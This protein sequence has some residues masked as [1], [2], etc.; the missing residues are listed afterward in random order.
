MR[1]IGVLPHCLPA[2]KKGRCDWVAE[3]GS[4]EIPDTARCAQALRQFGLSGNSQRTTAVVAAR[5][6]VVVAC[7]ER[8]TSDPISMILGVT[9]VDAFET[10][11][12][13]KPALNSSAFVEALGPGVRFGYFDFDAGLVNMADDV[14]RALGSFYDAAGDGAEV[15]EDVIDVHLVDVEIARELAGTSESDSSSSHLHYDSFGDVD[16]DVAFVGGRMVLSYSGGLAVVA[17]GGQVRDRGSFNRQYSQ[18]NTG[19]VGGAFAPVFFSTGSTQHGN[20]VRMLSVAWPMLAGIR[21]SGGIV[22]PEMPDSMKDEIESGYSGLIDLDADSLLVQDMSLWFIEANLDVLFPDNQGITDALKTS[23]L[24][25][26]GLGNHLTMPTVYHEKSSY[27]GSDAVRVALALLRTWISDYFDKEDCCVGCC[28][29]RTQVTV[30]DLSAVFN[31]G[32]GEVRVRAK[33]VEASDASGDKRREWRQAKRASTSEHDEFTRREPRIPETRTACSLARRSFPRSPRIPA[34]S[35]SF[36]RTN[37]VPLR[38]T[39]AHARFARR[40][41]ATTIC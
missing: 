11:R 27:G 10:L 16:E 19:S 25:F 22:L 32:L 23:L 37:L 6:D 26:V 21:A 5:H 2:L 38:S 20:A 12:V 30:S 41:S 29:G 36:T 40:R 7:K 34:P 4:T 17:D 24:V 31:E 3:P 9:G 33:R 18:F 15:G 35:G 14:M 39:L 8:I 13:C 1:L 28:G